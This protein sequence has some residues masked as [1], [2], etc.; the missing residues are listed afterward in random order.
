MPKP[1]LRVFEH[2]KSYF[3][4]PLDAK[5]ARELNLR[6]EALIK[7]SKREILVPIR[8]SDN[9]TIGVQA[10][11]FVGIVELSKRSIQILPKMSTLPQEEL[12][13]EQSINNLLFMLSYTGKFQIPHLD[14]TS[15]KIFNGDFFEILIYMYANLLI[16][17]LRNSIHQEYISKEDNLTYLRGKFVFSRHMNINA[18]QKSRFYVRSDEFSSGNKLNQIFKYVSFQLL[19]STKSVINKRLL[20]EICQILQDVPSSK[21]I[22]HQDAKAVNFTRLNSRFE[23]SLEFA[24]LFLDKRSLAF[25]QGEFSSMTF[26]IDMNALFENFITTLLK[27][28]IS[29]IYKIQAQGP[30]KHLIEGIETKGALSGPLFR[31]KPD[32]AIFE[33]SSNNL[34]SVV[35]TKYKLLDEAENKLG[36]AQSD[37]YQMYA[38]AKIYDI[39]KIV[40]LYPSG[41]NKDFDDVTLFTPDGISISVI[42]IN[43]ECDLKKCLGKISDELLHK[44]GV[45]VPEV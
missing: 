42:T 22:T 45:Y 6:C 31:M 12:A 20:T 18:F 41:A 43:L 16:E 1:L 24:K 25:Q 7:Y 29:P 14:R 21:I 2:S 15:L 35:D 19:R 26:L 8:N 37:L 10:R 17:Q 33:S 32:I 23:A 34:V 30:I 9:Q 11:N 5:E 38:Y 28:N 4:A 40:L 13:S 44:L 3:E 36:I 39:K 27:R